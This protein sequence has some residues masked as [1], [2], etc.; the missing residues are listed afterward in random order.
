MSR[1]VVVLIYQKIK[2]F[3]KEISTKVFIQ[4]KMLCCKKKYLSRHV[5]SFWFVIGCIIVHV[6][7]HW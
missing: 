1:F 6:I 3:F 4:E 7:K 2:I 5:F